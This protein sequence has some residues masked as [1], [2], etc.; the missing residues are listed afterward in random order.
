MKTYK[1]SVLKNSLKV[2]TGED[3]NAEIVALAVYLRAGSIYE[4]PDEF[5]YAHLLEHM[6]LKGSGK[7]PTIF[8]VNV[9]LDRAGAF[10]QANTSAETIKV[11][12]EVAKDQIEKMMELLADI[13]IAPI[14][15]KQVLEKEKR[16]AILE[17]RQNQDK[18][19][20]RAMENAFKNM[21]D[22]HA[23]ATNVLGDEQ[24]ILSATIEKLQIYHKKY[25]NPSRAAII[26]SGGVSH[27]VAVSLT[28]KYFDQWKN[29][30][31]SAV[32]VA[33]PILH[34]GSVIN[35]AMPVSQATVR[36][37]FPRK[38]ATLKEFLS[39]ELTG[40]YLS[41]GHTS[42]LYS[43]LR[44]KLG[45]IY[46]VFAYASTYTTA[47]VFSVEAGTHSPK[48]VIDLITDRIFSLKKYFTE[49]LFEEYK[50]QLKNIFL[51][52]YSGPTSELSFLGKMWV[53][54]GKLVS[55]TDALTELGQISY[56]DVMKVVEDIF[57][58]DNLFIT[59][60]LPS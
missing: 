21:F 51:R 38:Q 7:Y 11:I 20:R 49:I 52:R 45:L 22:G 54:Y 42:L 50:D 36:L 2:I 31:D 25:F 23:L 41:Y 59:S 5:G 13:I 35:I 27:D 14:F 10:K 48:E 16:A 37:D 26:I 6:L 47:A 53:L 44:H 28:E 60:V 55:P 34:R 39:F 8:D 19:A 33:T 12:I 3:A 18:P 40:N 32:D 57:R 29:T 9:I 46:G 30:T 4:S 58:K 24:H 1:E 56:E 17:L 15:D 43:E